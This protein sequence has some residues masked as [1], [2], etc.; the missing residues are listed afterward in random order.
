MKAKKTTWAVYAR[1]GRRPAGFCGRYATKKEAVEAQR[2]ERMTTI[3][4]RE[5]M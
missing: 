1:F 5:R 3:I 4:K 2:S